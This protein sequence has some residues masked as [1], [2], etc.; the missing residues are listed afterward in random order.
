MR[1]KSVKYKDFTIVFIEDYPKPKS[2]D[3][4]TSA[5]RE[6]FETIENT[7]NIIAKFITTSAKAKETLMRVPSPKI[8]IHLVGPDYRSKDVGDLLEKGMAWVDLDLIKKEIFHIHFN[9]FLLGWKRKFTTKEF[10]LKTLAHETQHNIDLTKKYYKKV[11]PQVLERIKENIAKVEK[12]TALVQKGSPI[13]KMKAE[14]WAKVRTSLK[15]LFDN[16]Y[17][18][19]V[20]V[21]VSRLDEVEYSEKYLKKLEKNALKSIKEANEIFEKGISETREKYNIG[22]FNGLVATAYEIG[23]YM[24][25][26]IMFYKK[27]KFEA[28]LEMTPN[29]FIDVYEQ[30]APKPLVSLHKKSLL[31]YNDMLKTWWNAIESK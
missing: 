3:N 20:A 27:L 28:I 4:L 10:L 17:F 30:C 1:Y 13:E 26:A 29:R 18:E 22:S 12:Y 8:Q 6:N 31:C 5:Q 19:G 2:L 21:F 25:F 23:F 7:K 11:L 14:R 16:L 9:L 15:L 24:V